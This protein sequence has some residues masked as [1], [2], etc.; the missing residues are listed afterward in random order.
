[1]SWFFNVWVCV[2]VF[3][4]VWLCVRFWYCNV[5]SVYVVCSVMCRCLYIR[6][7]YCVCG[8]SVCLCYVMCGYGYAGFIMCSCA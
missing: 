3:C 7:P 4:N 2:F 5:V 6:V 8:V 1:M